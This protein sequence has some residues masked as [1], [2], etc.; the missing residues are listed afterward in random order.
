MKTQF[1]VGW[2]VEM[3]PGFTWFAIGWHSHTRQADSQCALDKGLVVTVMG[4]KVAIGMF[5]FYE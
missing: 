5:R 2:G 3:G 4:L 1:D